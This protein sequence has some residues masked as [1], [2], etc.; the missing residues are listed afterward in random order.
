[1]VKIF[2]RARR[3]MMDDSSLKYLKYAFGEIILVVLGILIALGINN[4][5]NQ[6][7]ETKS[8]IAYLQNIAINIKADQAKLATISTF[9]ENS[10]KGSRYFMEMIKSEDISKDTFK[11]YFSEHMRYS[12]LFDPY[13]EVNMSGFDALKNS[14]FL[15]KL[16]VDSLE[17]H[18]YEYYSLVDKIRSEEMSFNN[19]MEEMEYDMYKNNVAQQLINLRRAIMNNTETSDDM[20]MLQN[21]IRYPAF[22]GANSRN[23]N[24]EY[25]MAPYRDLKRVGL[26]ILEKIAQ[27]R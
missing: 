14:G 6:R 23:V 25:L 15:S 13:L 22:V 11:I 8:L 20:V 10:M 1:M 2:R 9:R 16:Q 4:W 12:P 21:V 24:V 19:F 18:L 27:F 3:Q 17:N 5:N 7:Q 26:I